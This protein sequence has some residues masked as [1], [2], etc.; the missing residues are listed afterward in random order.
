MDKSTGYSHQPL[1]SVVT[2][3]YN[4]E[5]HIAE[6]I[7]SVLAQT[8]QNWEY[9]VVNNCSKDRTS[10]IVQTYAAK[11]S[12]IRTHQNEEFVGPIKNHNIAFAQI[13]PAGKYCKM[14]HADDWLFP[15]CIERMVQVAENNPTVGIVGSYRLI[16]VSV[17]PDG[18]PATAAVL[19]GRELCQRTFRRELQVFGSPSSTLIRS[20]LIRQH[21]PFY[22]ESL[23]HADTEA[24]FRLLRECDFG[25]VHQVL[26][27]TRR[28]EQ[29]GTTTVAERYETRI[30]ENLCIL[31]RHGPFYFTAKEYEGLFKQRVKEYYR[32]LGRKYLQRREKEFFDYQKKG[33]ERMG[34]RFSRRKLVG[35]VISDIPHMLLNIEETLAGIK[36]VR[37]RRTARGK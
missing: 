28:H 24:C 23:L 37:S 30:L 20:D 8:Y 35:G 2:P 27:F 33:L 14:V 29:S 7:E 34:E 31:K 25:F 15:E 12:R 17:G 21:K 4:G 32:F 26:T 18:L 16:G 3:V 6:C 13:S 1:V 19:S 36:R 5:K 22:D 11:D 10:E 9:V